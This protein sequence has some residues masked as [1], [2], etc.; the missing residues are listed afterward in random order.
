[1]TATEPA[2]TRTGEPIL[3]V[4]GLGVHFWVDGSWYPAAI[5]LDYSVLP[6]EVMAIVGE[7][8]SGKSSSSM[9]LMGLLP[10]NARVSGS[11]K[12]RGREI[13]NLRGAQLRRLRGKDSTR[14]TRSGSRSS[15]R[16]AASSRSAPPRRATARSNCSGWSRSPTRRPR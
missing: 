13:A 1:M 2:A 12:L 4:K 15:R 3:E 16:S 9:A 10:S 14:S 6:G 7:S 11:I 8:G 5:D